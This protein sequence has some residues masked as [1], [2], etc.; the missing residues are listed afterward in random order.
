MNLPNWL[1]PSKTVPHSPWSA[2]GSMWK[3]KPLTYFI[4]CVGLWCCG[5]GDAF[6]YN[7]HIGQSP[8]TVLAAGIENKTSLSIGWA[9]VLVSACVLL[10]W[11]PLHNKLGIGTIANVI[12]CA[13]GLQVMMKYLP[14]PH[15]PALQVVQVLIGVGFF[16]FGSAI[17]IPAHLGTG[18]R[19]GLMTGLHFK[20]GIPV[21]RVRMSVEVLVMTVGWFL[22]GTVGLGT[23]IFA[24]TVGY[25]LAFWFKGIH[26]LDV[27]VRE[28]KTA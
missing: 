17:Y 19:D 11:I 8:W 3:A 12:L 23:I 16:A 15:S 26:I 2:H 27:Y 10:L 21:A 28:R 9:A 14:Q 4:M 24:T 1:K 6:L 22:G 18:P 25:G 5:T 7:A 13:S 20:T